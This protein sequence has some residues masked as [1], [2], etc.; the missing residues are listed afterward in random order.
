MQ[1]LNASKVPVLSMKG[2]DLDVSPMVVVHFNI[3]AM[4]KIG[5]A[6]VMDVSPINNLVNSVL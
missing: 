5:D 6:A 2:A 4:L 1:L 3:S